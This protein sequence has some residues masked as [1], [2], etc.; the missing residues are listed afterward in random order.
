MWFYQEKKPFQ[1]NIVNFF[2][3]ARGF[4]PSVHVTTF[5]FDLGRDSFTILSVLRIR[6]G[7]SAVPDPYFYL[8]AYPDPDPGSQTDADPDPVKTLLSQKVEF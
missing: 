2:W 4:D 7:F 5:V 8:S 1:I 3:K 6:I